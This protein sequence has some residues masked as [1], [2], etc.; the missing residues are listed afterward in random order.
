MLQTTTIPTQNLAVN[1]PIKINL[2]ECTDGYI[3]MYQHGHNKAVSPFA[4]QVM[5]ISACFI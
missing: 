2:A 4:Q 1:Q 5:T 3:H